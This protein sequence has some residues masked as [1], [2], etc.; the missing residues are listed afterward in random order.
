LEKRFDVHLL[1]EQRILN[2]TEWGVQSASNMLNASLG[3]LLILGF[4]YFIL[5]FMLAENK[6]MERFFFNWLPLK[7][8]NIAYLRVELNKLVYS[9]AIGIPMMGL[10]QGFA[11]LIGYS[12]AG[13]EN[14]WFWVLI[15]FITG[16]IPFLGVM[17]AFIPLA[18]L[19]FSN[20]H[21]G[22]AVFILIYG[23]VVIGTVDNLARMWLMNR[24]GHTHPLVTL[25]GVVVGLQLFGFV[26]FIFGPIMIAMFLLLVRI[27][28]KEFH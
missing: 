3:S 20:G 13:V 14:L 25:F 5:W 11:G 24:I 23:A 28:Q 8:Q 15:T 4:T 22:K 2:I 17:L 1:T 19:L 26:G 27:Y 12:L 6:Q 16:M 21:T 7:D 10:I 18:L 9:N